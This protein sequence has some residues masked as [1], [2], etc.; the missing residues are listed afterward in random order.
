[1]RSLWMSERQNKFFLFLYFWQYSLIVMNLQRNI[2]TCYGLIS[3]R[4]CT[5][6]AWNRMK[7]S[8]G[9]SCYSGSESIL[10]GSADKL[11]H[12]LTECPSHLWVELFQAEIV[13]LNPVVKLWSDERPTT[14]AGRS[15]LIGKTEAVF[16][17][18]V[19]LMEENKW[20]LGP[21][22]RKNKRLI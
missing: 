3:S 13:E 10:A 14:E 11:C 20:D 18:G 16:A 8:T 5:I 2:S 6:K 12:R 22:R 1:M 7:T 19:S 15:C 4:P 21:G 17:E 9:S